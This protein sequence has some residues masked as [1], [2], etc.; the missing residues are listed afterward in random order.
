MQ[1]PKALITPPFEADFNTCAR[2]VFGQAACPP[3]QKV[4][5]SHTSDTEVTVE[6]LEDRGQTTA[7]YTICSQP[8]AESPVSYI[9]LCGM[10][11]NHPVVLAQFDTLA[12][13]REYARMMQGTGLA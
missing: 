2:T 9:S 10:E 7:Y 6:Y 4:V 1:A 3:S 13:Y 12:D 8:G 5:P 11:Y